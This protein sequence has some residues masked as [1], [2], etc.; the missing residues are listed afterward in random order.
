MAEYVIAIFFLIIA[1]VLIA[2]F[3]LVMFGNRG[4]FDANA[5]LTSD[6]G[7]I[8]KTLVGEVGSCETERSPD[9]ECG[10][11]AISP[12]GSVD[13]TRIEFKRAAR[14]SDDALDKVIRF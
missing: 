4:A 12:R 2:S 3:F 7:G 10:G 11:K 6:S 8:F 14:I 5:K 1:L 9:L 13:P